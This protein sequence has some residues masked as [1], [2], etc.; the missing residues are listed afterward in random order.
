[1]IHD[2]DHVADEPGGLPFVIDGLRRGPYDDR[3]AVWQE[4]GLVVEFE[5][6]RLVHRGQRGVGSVDVR[7]AHDV[8]GQV[9][10][11]QRVIARG[12]ADGVATQHHHRAARLDVLG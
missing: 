6:P 3:V 1:M 9:D 11:P 7:F 12:V 8:A 10:L 4:L 5:D 2:D